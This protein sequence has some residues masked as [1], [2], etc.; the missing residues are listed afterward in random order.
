MARVIAFAG[1]KGGTGKSTLSHLA[2]HGAGSLPRPIPAVVV[3]T[4]P[5][6]ALAEG[7]RRYVVV[8]GR[9]PPLLADQLQRLL[10]VDHLLI[11]VDGVANRADVDRVLADIADLVVV[12]FGPSAQDGARAAANLDGLP[13]AVALPNRWPT[14]PGVARRARRWLEAVPSGR[15]LPPLKAI[16]RLDAL[17]GPDAYT[18]IAYEIASPARGLILELLARAGVDPNELT[19]RS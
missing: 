9:S 12:P 16:P 2:A 13:S 6:D 8:D 7:E 14:H 3:T 1:S 5:E 4:D 17:L 19:V 10:A 18:E 15:R 11:L